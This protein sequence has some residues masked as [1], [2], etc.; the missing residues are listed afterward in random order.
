MFYQ[1]SRH[2]LAQSTYE[3]NH[4]KHVV[5]APKHVGAAL[6]YSGCVNAEQEIGHG[7]GLGL[8]KE[9]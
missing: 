1:L 5:Y 6:E 2:P 8:R 9:T 4:P 3:I 7:K